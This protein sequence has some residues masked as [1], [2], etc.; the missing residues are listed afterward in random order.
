MLFRSGKVVFV[1]VFV[2]K[3]CFLEIWPTMSYFPNFLELQRSSSFMEKNECQLPRNT[4]NELVMNYLVTGK[5][6]KTLEFRLDLI[7]NPFQRDSKKPLKSLKMKLKLKPTLKPVEW[8]QGSKS[9]MR[10]KLEKSQKQF[11]WCTN[12]IQ[13]Y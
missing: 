12:F 2:S 3:Q 5:K 6:R 1:S 10:F 4:M 13:N 8:I 7:Q 9:E 11:Q